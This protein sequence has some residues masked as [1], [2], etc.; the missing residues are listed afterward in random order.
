M[1]EFYIS[2]EAAE[3]AEELAAGA[4]AAV[5]V[6]KFTEEKEDGGDE[7]TEEKEADG[8]GVTEDKEEADGDITEQGGSPLIS[9]GPLRF[10]LQEGGA[11]SD[12]ETDDAGN[13]PTDQV[14]DAAEEKEEGDEKALDAAESPAAAQ[15]DA[16]NQTK[17]KAK[18][19]SAEGLD[20]VIKYTEVPYAPKGDYLTCAFLFRLHNV[21]TYTHICRR[22]SG[23]FES[24]VVYGM[25]G[26]QP[27][28]VDIR[29]ELP[30]FVEVAYILGLW[31]F[32][33]KHRAGNRAT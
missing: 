5:E 33:S 15:S 14:E 10:S 4:E 28:V 6:D 27:T 7:P 9:E 21:S 12:M 8:D 19:G 26:A 23:D 30:S 29:G 18:P 2:E 24:R 3:A 1:F 25:K 16:A 17:E 13:D 22:H 20:C 31:I 32:S 11:P